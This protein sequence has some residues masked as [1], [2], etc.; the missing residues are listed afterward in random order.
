MLKTLPFNGSIVLQNER[1]PDLKL[2]LGRAFLM[3]VEKG[4][5][6]MMVL[7]ARAFLVQALLNGA[8]KDTA[9]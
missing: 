1:E 8:V 5:R 9:S 4:D 6:E 7:F 3:E 2:L